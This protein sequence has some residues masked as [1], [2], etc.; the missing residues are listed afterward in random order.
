MPREPFFSRPFV[1][2]S[3]VLAISF[4]VAALVL[5]FTLVSLRS[6]DDTIT[7]TGSSKEIVKADSAKWSLSISRSATEGSI[8][9]GY[10]ALARDV[11][12]VRK[13]LLD[14][15][16]TPEQIT[17]GSISVNQEYTSDSNAPRRY[18]VYQSIEVVSSDVEKIKTL[19]Q[20]AGRL[21]QEGFMVNP[22]PPQYFISN[23]PDLRV[24]LLGKAVEDAKN[25][26]EE[27]AKAGGASVGN[28]KS[29]SSG[30]VQVLAPNSIE[31]QDYGSYD[32][33]TIDKEV[34]ITVRATF[35]IR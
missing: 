15:G 30:V 2:A 33:S 1:S 20:G 16:V 11:E 28:L 27:L 32:T 25:R 3:I 35:S 17:L 18:S 34:M 21:I 13:Y 10:L 4:I 8:P 5:A 9:A 7:A 24:S 12:A 26:A 29:A 31:V 22:N 19:S 23:L 6:L 14:G